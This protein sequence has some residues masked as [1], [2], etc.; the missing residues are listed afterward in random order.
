MTL[1]NEKE[2]I[3]VYIYI[4]IYIYINI[5]IYI[6]IYINTLYQK[7]RR[8]LAPGCLNGISVYCSYSMNGVDFIRLL[9]DSLV[10]QLYHFHYFRYSYAFHI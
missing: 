5:Y 9:S 6:Y 1:F 8:T 3:L 4:Y 7:L 2:K 10:S